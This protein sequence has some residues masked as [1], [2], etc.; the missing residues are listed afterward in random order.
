MGAYETTCH[1]T[2]LYP[3]WWEG[4]KFATPVSA[5]VSSIRNS[6]TKDILQAEL[7]GSSIDFGSGMVPKNR[8]AKMTRKAG[9]ADAIETVYVRFGTPTC[10]CKY[11][12]FC[13]DC[14]L[15]H[16]TFKSYEQGRTGF[17]GTKQQVIWLDEEP[18]DY[19]IFTE[20]LTR[21][22]DK[23][24]PGIIYCTFTPLFGL[25][26]VVLQFLPEGKIPSNG[27]NPKAPFRFVTQVEWSEVPHL[28]EEQKGE[29]LQSYSEHEKL[30]RSKGIPSL[31]AGAIYPYPE[32]EITVEPFPIPGYWPR[33][34][35]MDVG[36]NKTCAIWGAIDPSSNQ[37]YLYSEHYESRAAPAIHA[38]AIRAR[39]P[40]IVGVV[41]PA[42][43]KNINNVDGKSLLA[44]YESEGLDLVLANNAPEAGIFKMGQLLES[45]QLKVFSTLRNW[46]VE[47][48]L[49][50]RNEDGKI[51]KRD[52]HLMDATRYLVMT[53]L[54]YTSLSPS[55]DE[56]GFSSDYSRNDRDP[57]TG[58]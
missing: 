40:W 50:R 54:D 7:L 3:T 48:R 6:D 22:M 24:N 18:T 16:C 56:D 47:Y 1:L 35:G 38:A 57:I 39:G 55:Y 13:E 53:G 11:L 26:E 9:V 31:G 15:S 8:I 51:V 32:D 30:A 10:K 58:Y 2:G 4:K 28:N 27:I 36:W 52:D 42:A 17:Q 20:C 23:E 37:I 29:L 45:G 25:S 12:E 34:Y 44:L 5:W 33:V 43:E 46:L 41:D 21:T 14:V 19:G 49:Y